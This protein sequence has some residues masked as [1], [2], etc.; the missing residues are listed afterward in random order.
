MEL[1]IRIP[2]PAQERYLRGG[3]FAFARELRQH[4]RRETGVVLRLCALWVDGR[5]EHVFAIDPEA[6]CAYD[7][8]GRLPLDAAALGEG[9]LCAGAGEIGPITIAQMREWARSMDGHNARLD[10]SRH[11]SIVHDEE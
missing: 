1:S 6:G 4:V 10:I 11:V 7:A 3:C 5:P 8:R 9:S 2:K